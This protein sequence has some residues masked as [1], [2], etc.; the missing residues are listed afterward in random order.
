MFTEP[1]RD[2]LIQVIQQREGLAVNS[3]CETV[4]SISEDADSAYIY[5]CAQS[6]A[7]TVTCNR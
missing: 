4:D 5:A 6:V 2:K 7:N 1:P 3:L